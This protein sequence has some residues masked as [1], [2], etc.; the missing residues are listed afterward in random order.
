MQSH[1]RALFPGSAHT[2]V[3]GRKVAGLYGAGAWFASDV[4]VA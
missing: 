3:S 4:Q 2:S 1:T